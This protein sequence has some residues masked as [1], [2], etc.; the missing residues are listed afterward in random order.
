MARQGVSVIIGPVEPVIRR[1]F[2]SVCS[3]PWEIRESGRR[4]RSLIQEAVARGAQVILAPWDDVA[5]MCGGAL[6]DILVLGVSSDRFNVRA[7]REGK[8]VHLRNPRP[9][10]VM[11]YVRDWWARHESDEVPG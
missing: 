2:L 7:C 1:S 8:V 9:E 10:A 6:L 3:G 5:D 11:A 4:G